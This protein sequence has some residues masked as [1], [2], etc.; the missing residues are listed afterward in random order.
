MP[1]DAIPHLSGYS[2]A[3]LDAAFAGVSREVATSAATLETPEAVEQF[4]LH[5]IGRK[6]GRLK[7]ISDA[8]LKAAPAEAKKLIGQ[9]FNIG[10]RPPAAR[11]RRAHSRRRQSTSPCLEQSARL[12]PS[13]RLSRPSTSWLGSFSAWATPSA[14]ARK[15]RP[16]TTISNH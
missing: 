1:E 13:I 2:E 16:T 7:A 11:S 4:R 3:E 12:G 14:W 6:Q 15:S 8:W 10:W 5:W 9:R